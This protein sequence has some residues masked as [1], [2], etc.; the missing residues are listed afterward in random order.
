VKV[1]V[2][3][4][5]EPPFYSTAPDGSATGSDI[6]LAD[7][8][9]RAAGVSA[10]ECVPTTFGELIP[11]L[12]AGRWDVNVPIFVTPER[13]QL[14]AFSRPVWRLSDGLV[15]KRGTPKRLTSY[16][17]VAAHADARLGV[18]PSQ[19][20]FDAARDAGVSE[21]RLVAFADQQAAVTALL[22]GE[23]DAFAATAVGNR[24]ITA[25]HPDLQDVDVE[26][27]A[28]GAPV[29]AFSFRPGDRLRGEV[30]EALRDY[31]GT[32]DHRRRM[33]AYGF[34]PSEIDGALGRVE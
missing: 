9:L 25:A 31:L 4:V 13:A 28:A 15:V 17:A 11:G 21:S 12:V 16:S 5:E 19:V 33:A 24:A 30:D 26:G 27:A 8:V 18:I 1:R 7:V 2:A 29:G 20:Q 6:E 34:G 23:I 32:D 3:Y 22:A 10:V 14:V